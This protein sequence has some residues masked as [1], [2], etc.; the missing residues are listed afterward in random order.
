MTNEEKYRQICKEAA[1]TGGVLA[2]IIVFWIVAG[3]G[4]AQLDITIGYLPLWAVTSTIGT[5]LFA[6]VLVKLLTTKVFK[7]MSL[8]DEEARHDG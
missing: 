2:A 5:W 1:A 4:V 3:F 7:D 8:E 6:I